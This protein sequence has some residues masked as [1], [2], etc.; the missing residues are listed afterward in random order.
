VYI[1]VDGRCSGLAA[2]ADPVRSDAAQAVR[3]M[4]SRGWRVAILS[5]DHPG[6]VATVAS[7]VG[8]D[9]ESCRGGVTPEQKLALVEEMAR[10][11]PVVMVGDGV[12]D[13][14]ALAAATVGIAVRGGAEASLHAADIAM[15]R[16]GLTPIVE[17]LDGA[18]RTMRTIHWT[19]AT[20]LGY[21]VVAASLSMC[22]LIS[23]LLAAIIMPASS[24]TVVAIC[25][26]SGAFRGASPRGAEQSAA[27]ANVETVARSWTPMQEAVA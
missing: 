8:I 16:E 9:R 10:Q 24:L 13:A 2:L 6:V 5:G 19:I 12:N 7:A 1:S 20:S 17:V 22:G 23:P 26:R 15:S 3:G 18:R 25:L 27:D 21:N 4:R 14:A 11:G